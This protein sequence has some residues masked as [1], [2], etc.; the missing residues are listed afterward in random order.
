MSTDAGGGVGRRRGGRFTALLVGTALSMISVD[1]RADGSS[2]FDPLRSVAAAAFGPVERGVGALAI[3]TA[4]GDAMADSGT[5]ALRAEV[6]TLTAQL[7]RSETDRRRVA[8][9]D[10]LLRLSGAGQY[11]TVPALVVAF[12][13]AEQAERTVTIDAGRLDG[14]ATDMTVVNGAGLVGRV[15][16]TTSTT[17]TVQLAIDSRAQLGVRLEGSLQLGVARGDGATLG[18]ELLDRLEPFVAGDRVVT[19]GSPDGRPYVAGVPV[20]ELSRVRGDVGAPTRSA[21][22]T[23]YVDFS[24]LD[25][26]GVVVEP[27][28]TDPRDAVLPPTPGATMA[29]TSPA[30]TL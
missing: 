22:L 3:S 4:A 2:P 14:V 19:F 26:V 21:V 12:A 20:G 6:D 23:P 27:P 9:L 16:A 30:G 29:R 15:V 13:P 10:A 28:R 18:V 11:R 17:A 1:L 8:E 25:L 7:R 24:A 5:A